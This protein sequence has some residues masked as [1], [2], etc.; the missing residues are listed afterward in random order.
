MS[1]EVLT[2][3]IGSS[4]KQNDQDLEISR[5]VDKLNLNGTAVVDYCIPE[6]SC[7]QTPEEL[8]FV[9]N[10]TNLDKDSVSLDFGNTLQKSSSSCHITLKSKT[11]QNNP[12]DYSLFLQFL[13]ECLVQPGQ[14]LVTVCDVNS[15]ICLKKHEN[16]LHHWEYFDYGLNSEN[17][18]FQQPLT[19]S[20]LQHKLNILQKEAS[21]IIKENDGVPDDRVQISYMSNDRLEISFEEKKTGAIGV[22]ENGSDDHIQTSDLSWMRC[23][24]SA[25]SSPDSNNSADGN[26]STESSCVATTRTTPFRR[27]RS[28]S[29]SGGEI[30]LKGIL[31]NVRRSSHTTS[32][33]SDDISWSSLDHQGVDSDIPE[34]ESSDA[35]HVKKSVHFN[36]NVYRSFFRSNSSIL[37]QR[38]KN[39]KKQKKKIELRRRRSSDGES[40]NSLEADEISELQLKMD[41]DLEDSL[42][43]NQNHS[44]SSDK[45]GVISHCPEELD[46]DETYITKFSN[47]TIKDGDKKRGKKKQV[48]ETS[49][50]V[51][52]G[53]DFDS[54]V[55]ELT[56]SP[57]SHVYL[58]QRRYFSRHRHISI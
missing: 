57:E 18:T 43:I 10:V 36:D 15:V 49:E 11:R 47:C 8:V 27:F 55:I 14:E 39:R 29:E 54:G 5:Q 51:K 56:S 35:S 40:N 23:N 7:H 4:V 46:N 37:G 30:H 53:N 19:V 28:I 58:R 13:P 1:T 41:F 38:E 9:F 44:S 22:T 34:E 16:S 2:A 50:S 42:D 3:F 33:S 45:M 12:N 6:F 48:Q 24:G 21:R 31:K 26:R 32:E 52:N 20:A 17:T 25:D